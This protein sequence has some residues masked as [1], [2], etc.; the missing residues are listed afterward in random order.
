MRRSENLSSSKMFHSNS[1]HYEG[2]QDHL[3]SFSSKSSDSR[4]SVRW[5]HERTEMR[6]HGVCSDT[7]MESFSNFSSD[8][9]RGAYL[10][11]LDERMASDGIRFLSHTS[12]TRD[13]QNSMRLNINDSIQKKNLL[14][15]YENSSYLCNLLLY[16]YA[17]SNT[18]SSLESEILSRLHYIRSRN[19]CSL[20]HWILYI[21]LWLTCWVFRKSRVTLLTCEL[22]PSKN[23][24]SLE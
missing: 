5:Y 10:N 6:L 14:R 24:E 2:F 8:P 9:S 20:S 15:K 23:S 1:L 22:Y 17:I 4:G 12:Q 18:R 7:M 19:S 16:V 21:C 3:S 11:L 13:Q